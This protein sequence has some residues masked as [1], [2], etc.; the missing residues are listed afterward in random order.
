MENGAKHV[1]AVGS[2]LAGDV[3][4]MSIAA[5]SIQQD[6]TNQTR[7]WVIAKSGQP[8]QTSRAMEYSALKATVSF[9]T[10]HETGALADALQAVKSNGWNLTKI[11]SR[12]VPDVPWRYRFFCDMEL[13]PTVNINEIKSSLHSLEQAKAMQLSR[14]LGVYRVFTF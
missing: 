4:E 12:P 7:F 11:E 1:G 14:L 10:S 3:Y 8:P 9:E 2:A 5:H 13:E 6:A